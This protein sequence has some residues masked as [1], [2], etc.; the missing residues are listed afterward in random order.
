VGPRDRQGQVTHPTRVVSLNE[1]CG[2]MRAPFVAT[3]EGVTVRCATYG[4]DCTKGEIVPIRGGAPAGRK[5][6][7]TR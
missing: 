6:P 5:V 7:A 3:Y 2:E 4:E 1:E